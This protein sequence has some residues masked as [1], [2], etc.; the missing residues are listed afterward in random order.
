MAVS[1]GLPAHV[2]VARSVVVNAPETAIFPYLNDLHNFKDWSPWKKR[3]PDLDIAHSGNEK[4]KGAAVAWTSQKRSVGTGSME[5][6]ESEPNRHIGMQVNF[7]GLEGTSAF[8]L[9][10]AGSGSKLTWNFGFETGSS[11]IKR[12]KGLMLDSLVGPEYRAALD[13]VKEKVETERRPTVPTASIP[14]P[15]MVVPGTPGMA[16]MPGAEL[17]PGAAALP[18]AVVPGAVMAPGTTVPMT[19]PP[20]A[21]QQAVPGTAQQ[22][23]AGTPQ[24]AQPEPEE[25]EPAPPPKPKRRRRTGQR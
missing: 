16:P 3:D 8:E 13:T 4:G 24:A 18:G 17:V 25:A 6:T 7:N 22:P 21:M 23:A 2:T 1:I 19:M 14:V 10:P 5:I 15:G 20:G 9:T 12:W 11:P